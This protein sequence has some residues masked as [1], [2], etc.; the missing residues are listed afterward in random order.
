MTSPHF[1]NGR[2]ACLLVC[3]VLFAALESGCGPDDGIGKRYPVSGTVTYKDKPL[4][5]GSINFVPVDP[6]TGRAASGSVADGA[7]TLMTQEPGDG[8]LPGKYKVTVSAVEV[9]L[10]KASDK[11]K[12]AGRM[13]DQADIAKAKRTNLVPTKYLTPETSGLTA[14]VREGSNTLDFPLTD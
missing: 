7:Y 10:S 13:I 6:A 8:A 3:L 2:R 4:P 5:K 1:L 12:S 11:A 9:D 14:E